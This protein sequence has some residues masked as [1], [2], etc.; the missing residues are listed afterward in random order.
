MSLKIGSKQFPVAFDQLQNM[1]FF[2]CQHAEAAGFTGALLSKIELAAEEALSN[3]IR[4]SGLT[5]H[6]FLEILCSSPES[7]GI[8]IEIQ[9]SGIPYNPLQG[10][11]LLDERRSSYGILLI[12][13]LMDAVN[14]Q[15][16]DNRNI[17]TLTKYLTK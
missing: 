15:R 1:L 10:S 13:S 6:H 16:Q 12:R 7:P 11:P 3:I 4:Y 17:L 5:R 14:Y 9:D 2:V 8:R